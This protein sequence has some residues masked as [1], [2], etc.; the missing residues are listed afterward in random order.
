[1]ELAGASEFSSAGRQRRSSS[2]ET[3]ADGE[4]RGEHGGVGAV[5]ACT[6]G[7]GGEAGCVL[8]GCSVGCALRRPILAS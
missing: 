8:A 5:T 3:C 2:C 7:C 4:D 1:M 6:P